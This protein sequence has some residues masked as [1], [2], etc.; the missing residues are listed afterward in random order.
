MCGAGAQDD[1]DALLTLTF[2]V[3]DGAEEAA[4][5]AK[6]REEEQAKIDA[7]LVRAGA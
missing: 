6:R 7:E 3:V 2:P 5:T 1:I 4:A